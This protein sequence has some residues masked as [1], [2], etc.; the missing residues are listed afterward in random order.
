MDHDNNPPDNNHILSP[1][2]NSSR[3]VIHNLSV[4][5]YHLNTPVIMRVGLGG[6]LI[7]TILAWPPLVFCGVNEVTKR[8][9]GTDLLIS[10]RY[11]DEIQASWFAIPTKCLCSHGWELSMVLN[12]VE[13]GHLCWYCPWS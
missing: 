12:M 9:H 6:F 3:I 5:K 11:S 10:L 7:T 1:D 4:L 13:A 2:I 8:S